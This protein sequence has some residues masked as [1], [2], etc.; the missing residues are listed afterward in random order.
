MNKGDIVKL[1]D[2]RRVVVV[3]LPTS[4]MA[5]GYYEVLHSDSQDKFWVKSED[6][7]YKIDEENDDDL[8]NYF[9]CIF[10]KSGVNLIPKNIIGIDIESDREDINRIK[11][12]FTDS[13]NKHQICNIHIGGTTIK[14]LGSITEQPKKEEKS[15]LEKIV[16]II[17]PNK[18]EV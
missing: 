9:E 2:N 5:N 1:V 13:T 8:N 17:K 6:I 16:E 7:L 4:F 11:L 14:D 15:K 12:T 18:D 10:D 3:S